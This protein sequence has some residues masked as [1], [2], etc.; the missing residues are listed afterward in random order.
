MN[1]AVIVVNYGSS[2]LLASHLAALSTQ[3]PSLSMIVVDC[4]SGES[5]RE[6][7][8][9]LADRYGWR[10]VLLENNVGF[11]GGVNRGAEI[12][13]A[14]GAEVLLVV[15][16]DAQL[17]ADAASV[18]I[19]SAAA[20]PD[21]LVAPVVRRPDGSVWSAGMDV[22]LDDGSLAG[23]RFRHRR[24]G[25]PRRMWLSGACFALSSALWMRVGGFAEDYFLYWEDVDLSYRV[26][27]AGGKLVIEESAVVVHDEGGT[28][29]AIRPGRTRSELFYYYNIRNRLL[30]A[31]R[32]L[33]AAELRAWRRATFRVSYGTLL[34][35]GRRQLVTSIAPWRALLRGMRDG[36]RGKV[37]PL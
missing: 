13:L 9:G 31:R 1:A 30:Y 21:S 5:E 37:G 24:P 26:I 17:R 20:N 35:G 29:T 27:E 25:R 15:N 32:N 10:P 6:E 3:D 22:Y 18:L 33:S 28:Q 16:P 23:I 36:L 34:G 4:F 14:A 12:A 2:G 8:R 19:G 11:G 7:V